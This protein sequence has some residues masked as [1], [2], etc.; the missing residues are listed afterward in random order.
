M[1][2]VLMLVVVVMAALSVSAQDIL[3]EPCITS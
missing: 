1:K 3:I 2:K